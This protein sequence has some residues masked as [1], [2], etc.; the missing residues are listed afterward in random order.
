MNKAL[1][2]GRCSQ[3]MLNK[4]IQRNIPGGTF[5][6]SHQVFDIFS[7]KLCSTTKTYNLEQNVTV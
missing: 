6:E 3:N 5:S 1:L 7:E 4:M 2:L